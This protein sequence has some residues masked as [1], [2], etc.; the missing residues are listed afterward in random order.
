MFLKLRRMKGTKGADAKRATRIVV[1]STNGH[2]M[3]LERTTHP[4][5]TVNGSRVPE[6]RITGY[7][8]AAFIEGGIEKIQDRVW[9]D[10]DLPRSSSA[11]VTSWA[12]IEDLFDALGPLLK[13]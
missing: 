10:A 1:S 8:P 2:I 12:P 11:H 13:R 6:Y 3:Q 7:N 5:L 4:T 9:I